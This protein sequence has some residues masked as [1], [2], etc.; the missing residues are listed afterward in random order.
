[1]L[2]SHRS[3]EAN[4]PIFAVACGVVETRTRSTRRYRLRF[5]TITGSVYVRDVVAI[6]FPAPLALHM[7]LSP[8]SWPE[9][10]QASP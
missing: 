5:A 8:A 4:V 3:L 6:C 1:M 9:G 2:P 10:H 7:A